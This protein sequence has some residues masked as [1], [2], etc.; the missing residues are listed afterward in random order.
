M[1]IYLFSNITLDDNEVS[2]DA[3]KKVKK[4]AKENHIFQLGIKYKKYGKPYFSKEKK[5]HFNISH[6]MGITAICFSNREIGIDIERAD[7]FNEKIITNFFNKAEKKEIAK[8]S[9]NKTEEK[10]KAVEI[11][12]RKEAIGKCRGEGLVLTRQIKL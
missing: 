8:Y 5:V 6:T 9:K 7:Y 11:W 2:K 1:E 3:I 10:M 4:I 12:T